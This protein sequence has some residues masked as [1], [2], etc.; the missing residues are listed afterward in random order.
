MFNFAT[1]FEVDNFKE[2][3]FRRLTFLDAVEFS[4]ASNES[5]E[6]KSA[7]L[8]L[9]YSPEPRPFIDNFQDFMDSLK[10]KEIDLFGI[11]N[12]GKLLGVGIYSFI[13][14]SPNGC[15]IV[16]WMRKSALGKNMG[17]Y[18][19]KRLTSHAFYKKEFRFVELMIDETNLASRRMAEKVGYVH[20]ESFAAYTQGEKGS[21]VLCRYMCFIGEIVA[22]AELY[23]KRAIDLIDHPA[24]EIQFRYLIYNENVNEAFKW[25][26]PII[27]HEEKAE[28]PKK[29]RPRRNPYRQ[30]VMS[31]SYI[32]K[33]KD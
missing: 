25:P 12:E 31:T 20:I 7:Y 15:Q 29:K 21:G 13:T 18:F 9:G 4:R 30:A 19:L 17:T 27:E 8:D 14:Y 22:L 28:E 6:T 32:P 1:Q 5:L 2:F 3:T 33:Y 26:Y 23:E 11:F 24:Y 10:S 16:I